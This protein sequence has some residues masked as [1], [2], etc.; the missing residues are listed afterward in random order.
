MSDRTATEARRKV[1]ASVFVSLDDYSAG[2]G[3]VSTH[4]V[5]EYVGRCAARWG[6]G[7]ARL[8]MA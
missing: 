6:I 7:K 8:V 4:L 1:I 2:P 5:A 3:N